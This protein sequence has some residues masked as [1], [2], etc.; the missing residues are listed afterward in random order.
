MQAILSKNH[1]QLTNTMSLLQV[2]DDFTPFLAKLLAKSYRSF[3]EDLISNCMNVL[4][5]NHTDVQDGLKLEPDEA[6][7]LML[8]QFN[9]I[10]ENRMDQMEDTVQK[11]KRGRKPKTTIKSVVAVEDS[12]DEHVENRGRPKKEEAKLE[13]IPPNPSEQ[14]VL[15]RA[16]AKE[17]KKAKAEKKVKSKKSK[18]PIPKDELPI[19]RRIHK[20]VMKNGKSKISRPWR[21]AEMPLVKGSEWLDTW[22]ASKA[23]PT[24]TTPK[25]DTLAAAQNYA[26]SPPVKEDVKVAA[27]K[28][29]VKVAAVEDD[30]KVAAV[31]D[32]AKVAAEIVVEED[33]NVAAV[34]DDAKVAAVVDEVVVEI[35][36][37]VTETPELEAEEFEEEELDENVN[38][39]EIET[40]LT[41]NEPFL[42]FIGCEE[43]TDLIKF[44]DKESSNYG[45][46]VSKTTGEF[47]GWVDPDDEECSVEEEEQPDYGIND[48]ESDNSSVD[49]T[50]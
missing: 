22:A 1:P 28:E 14:A 49:L 21:K 25:F 47:F 7:D 11:K 33:V 15:A 43:R 6:F 13:I 41:L 42:P 9:E 50:W 34:E 19:W 30:A 8:E 24:K 35:I 29:D 20:T 2:I 40:N 37:K 36:E 23:S 32:D 46:I 39:F 10:L 48:E 27:V 4:R 45:R 31:E 26:K 17:A 5:K 18:S 38:N 3:G 16:E 44:T 12:E